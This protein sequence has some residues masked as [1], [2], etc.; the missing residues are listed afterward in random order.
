MF[1]LV[2]A[3][4][5][6]NPLSKIHPL[7]KIMLSVLPIVILGYCNNIVIIIFNILVITLIHIKSKSPIKI[8]LRFSLGIVM[9]ASISCVTFIFDYGIV[10]CLIIILKGLSGGLCLSYLALTTPLDDVLNLVAKSNLLRDVCDITKSM[11]RFLFL[12]EDE[13]ITLQNAM[14]SRGGFDSIVLR[15]KSSGKLLGVLFINTLRKW[16]EIKDVINSRCFKGYMSYM[17]RE[18]SF[19]IYRVLAITGYNAL[20]IALNFKV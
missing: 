2:S 1:K 4:A 12:I 9:F 11:E 6:R 14:K 15:I 5:K 19:S 8:V 16:N 10:F 20:L 13:F 7:E 17:E 3:Y 18:Y